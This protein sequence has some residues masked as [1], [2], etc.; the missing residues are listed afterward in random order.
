MFPELEPPSGA[1]DTLGER[2]GVAEIAVEGGD[3]CREPG[4]ADL[5]HQNVAGRTGSGPPQQGARLVQLT[6][7]KVRSNT[8]REGQAGQAVS[9]WLAADGV[10]RCAARGGPPRSTDP[11]RGGARPRLLR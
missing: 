11:D 1:R 4:M 7:L 10:Q 6:S 9:G 3:P 2:V 8:D 5:V